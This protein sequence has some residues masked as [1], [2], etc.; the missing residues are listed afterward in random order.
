MNSDREDGALM[1]VIE[2]FKNIKATY[3][4]LLE[5]CDKIIFESKPTIPI[6]TAF[7]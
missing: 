5:L 2:P 3:K 1:Q 6:P 4:H 7:H